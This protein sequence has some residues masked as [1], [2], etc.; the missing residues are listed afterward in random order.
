MRLVTFEPRSGGRSRAGVLGGVNGAERIV[1]LEAALGGP[2]PDLGALLERPEVAAAPLAALL[3]RLAPLEEAAARGEG[4]PLEAELRAPV[5][6][7]PK[8]TCVGV[9]YRD[10]AREMK[11]EPPRAPLLFAKARTSAAGPFDPILAGSPEQRVDW[12]AELAVVVGRAGFRVPRERAREHVLGFT[13]ACDVTDRAAQQA[14]GQW[15][16]GKSGPGFCPHGP[17]VVTE[18]SIDPGRLRITTQVRWPLEREEE[19]WLDAQ[20]GTTADMIFDVDAIVS[21]VSHA[22]P[23]EAGDLIL[24]GTPAG[25]GHGRT[26]PRYLEPGERV[27]CEI[28]G[29]GRISCPVRRAPWA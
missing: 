9:N 4:V 20:D 21:C 19:A 8:I 24:T 2:V 3:A 16:R 18:G 15:Y 22:A 10:H 13:V 26:P 5:P 29:I 14:D 27:V 25:V 28:E 11:K 7:P 23:L 6:R 12:E 1:P 17:L